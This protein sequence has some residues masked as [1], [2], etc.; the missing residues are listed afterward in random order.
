MD[1][2]WNDLYGVMTGLNMVT[3]WEDRN[4]MYYHFPKILRLKQCH[5]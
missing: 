4:A 3:S 2:A 1:L 5:V